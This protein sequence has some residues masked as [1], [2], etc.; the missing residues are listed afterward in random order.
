MYFILSFQ[1]YCMKWQDALVRISFDA[2]T[3]N[4]YQQYKIDE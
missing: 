2:E 3:K 4:W 1:E